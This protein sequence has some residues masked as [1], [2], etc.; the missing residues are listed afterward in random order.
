MYNY[1]LTLKADPVFPINWLV[2]VRLN[3]IYPRL[4]IPL[5]PVLLMKVLWKQ[6]IIYNDIHLIKICDC[7]SQNQ[8]LY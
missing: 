1:I 2:P 3:G 4:T 5:L 6:W 7:P 8:S